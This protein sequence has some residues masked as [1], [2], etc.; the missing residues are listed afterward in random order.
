[1]LHRTLRGWG[2]WGKNQGSTNT[3]NF[4]KLIIGKI[5]NV[6]AARCHI[7]RLQ[8]TKFDS[9]LVARLPVCSR[10]IDKRHVRWNLTIILHA[11]VLDA[12]YVL[13]M[14]STVPTAQYNRWTKETYFPGCLVERMNYSDRT[15]RQ[16]WYHGANGKGPTTPKHVS[17][18]SPKQKWR[19]CYKSSRIHV[20]S[21]DSERHQ[22]LTN[23]R[24]DGQEPEVV[25]A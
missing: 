11:S 18:F 10:T 23:I 1:M 4:V 6:T 16:G 17:R 19:P 22:F 2:W 25:I 8:C 21:S 9:C 20:T 14:L 24:H 3:L 12:C 7:L 15:V 5:A 13:A